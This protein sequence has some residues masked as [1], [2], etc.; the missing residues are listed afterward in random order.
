ME[1]YE[2][3]FVQPLD[4]DAALVAARAD[5]CTSVYAWGGGGGGGGGPAHPPLA[6]LAPGGTRSFVTRQLVTLPSS[7]DAALL[8]PYG[9]AGAAV[10]S[11]V[12][13]WSVERERTRC[14]HTI[15]LSEAATRRGP[16]IVALAPLGG[17]ASV[18]NVVGVSERLLFRASLDARQPRAVALRNQS[19]SVLGA[20]EWR[21][22]RGGALTC[23]C[24]LADGRCVTASERGE[25]ALYSRAG[26]RA[27]L[28]FSL[29]G[30]VRALSVGETGDTGGGG[31]GST[32]VCATLD[33]RVCVV[34]PFARGGWSSKHATV[35]VAHCRDTDTASS[36]ATG[37]ASTVAPAAY[38]HA[39]VR[40]DPATAHSDVVV[41][42]GEHMLAFALSRPRQRATET[43]ARADAARE[44]TL[45]KA[46]KGDRK[47]VV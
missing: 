13:E 47:S 3:R 35:A 39:R 16:D 20:N 29:G 34:G 32:Y 40:T 24:A 18:V 10:G 41:A 36:D 27:R 45:H 22:V 30:A 38:V 11:T 42:R 26:E 5:E 15:V 31:G 4:R 33:A 1:H 9:V 12:V 46:L 8:V 19:R 28:L 44:D 17:G 6:T 2:N 23:V 7:S 43:S 37:M 21:L 14:A 25:V